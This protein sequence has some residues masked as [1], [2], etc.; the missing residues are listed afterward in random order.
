MKIILMAGL[1]IIKIS[2][3]NA[4]LFSLISSFIWVVCVLV[5]LIFLDKNIFFLFELIRIYNY[6]IYFVLFLFLLIF[7]IKKHFKEKI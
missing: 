6:V 2:V 4:F 5:L 7:F 1:G 3:F